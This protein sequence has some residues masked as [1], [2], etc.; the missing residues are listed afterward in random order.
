MSIP[1]KKKKYKAVLSLKTMNISRNTGFIFFRKQDFCK[2]INQ[3]IAIELKDS[4]IIIIC[5]FLM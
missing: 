2:K 1:V 3:N 5:N 4:N